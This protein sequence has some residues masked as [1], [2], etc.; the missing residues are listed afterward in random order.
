MSEH[1][2]TDAPVSATPVAPHEAKL[3]ERSPRLTLT[4]G[5]SSKHAED[6][7]DALADLF[8]GDEPVED[9]GSAGRACDS[10]PSHSG[11]ALDAPPIE[12]LILGHLPVSAS[13]WVK[14]YAAMRARALGGP[15]GLIRLMG[16]S[17]AID[18][19]GVDS[20]GDLGENTIEHALE[21]LRQRAVGVV[22]RVDEMGEPDLARGAID[23]MVV[24][25]GG[26]EAAVVAAFRTIKSLAN[27]GDGRFDETPIRVAIVGHDAAGARD[28]HAR[29]SRSAMH[30]LSREIAFA[31]SVER[32][33]S[34]PSASLFHGEW[35]GTI[36]ML[37]EAVVGGPALHE[38]PRDEPS[39][40]AEYRSTDPAVGVEVPV[41]SMIEAETTAS[42]GRDATAERSRSDRT[43][44]THDDQ[45][46][47]GVSC[48]A[49]I[50]TGLENAGRVDADS[51]PASRADDGVLSDLIE[52]LAASE[53]RS[54]DAPE[55]EF[56]IDG[57]GR[58][59]VVCEIDRAGQVDGVLGWAVRHEALL[60]LAD[61]RI[62]VIDNSTSAHLVCTEAV[63]A[64]AMLDG[65]HR[66]HLLVAIE[67]GGRVVRVTRALN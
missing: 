11:V 27:Q 18:L 3:G 40:E 60:R 45:G 6:E 2:G 7:F 8:L 15:V 37:L 13:S 51:I 63:N 14:T 34:E 24:L 21:A 58:L 35:A 53:I 1:T 50:G 9:P 26:D 39:A 23:G 22:A 4:H 66:V 42:E 32:L 47:S 59:Q 30:S 41:G 54:P 17:L 25:S 57:D 55:I 16:G 56:A 43:S 33:A 62:R 20:R 52:G 49:V 29:L 36:G 38:G 48:D 10:E 28:A 65:R 61:P 19:V 12:G 5:L 46:E 44:E 67:V 31:G 64:R